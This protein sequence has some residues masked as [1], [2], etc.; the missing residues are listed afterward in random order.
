MSVQRL[1]GLLTHNL[2]SITLWRHKHLPALLP[3]VLQ[4]CIFHLS[5]IS[6]SATPTASPRFHAV[7]LATARHFSNSSCIWAAKRT[8]ASA[9]KKSRIGSADDM[10]QVFDQN[11]MLIGQMTIREAEELARRDNLKLVDMG[12][13]SDRLRSFRLVTGREL[14]EVSKRQRAE[15][16][17]EKVKEKEFRVA[18]NITDHDL[19]IKLGQVRNVLL[20]G[21]QVKFVIKAH[22]RTA[23]VRLRRDICMGAA[24]AAVLGTKSWPLISQSS[25]SFLQAS[26]DVV[27]GSVY[28][29]DNP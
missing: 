14:A 9:S 27:W 1:P 2:Y 15:K 13:N 23:E 24:G 16:K 5:R 18:S 11:E 22:R 19:D 10:C 17:S 6:S 3:R 12:E 20:R 25:F 7:S 4:S 21:A 28:N 26:K 8:T 29:S